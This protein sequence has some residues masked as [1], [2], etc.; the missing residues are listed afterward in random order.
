MAQRV[1]RQVVGSLAGGRR[2][3]GRGCVAGA[4]ADVVVVVVAAG[5]DV[6]QDVLVHGLQVLHHVAG[7]GARLVV[8][9]LVAD[10]ADDFVAPQLDEDPPG[11]RLVL[12]RHVGVGVGVVEVEDARRGRRG[13]RGRLGLR[14][15]R[16][17]GADP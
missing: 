14:A 3:R 10:P 11:H 15:R 7:A 9:L 5:L 16:H 6:G 12:P 13:R 4:V 17:R 8:H 2:G 1:R